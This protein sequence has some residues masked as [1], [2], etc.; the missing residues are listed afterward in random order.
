MSLIFGQRWHGADMRLKAVARALADEF[1]PSQLFPRASERMHPPRLNRFGV[2]KVDGNYIR[3]EHYKTLAEMANKMHW[4]Q[5][6]EIERLRRQL[7]IALERGP[8]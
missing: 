1:R 4:E 3:Y 6:R 2:P 5:Q 8:C 7:E